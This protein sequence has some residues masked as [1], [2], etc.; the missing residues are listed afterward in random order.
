MLMTEE[1]NKLRLRAQTIRHLIVDTTMKAGGAHIGGG[2]SMLD[3]LVTLYFKYMNIDP[4]IPDDPDRDRFVLSKGHAAIGYIPTLA[5]R[6][7]FDKSLLNTFNKFQSPFGMHPDSLKIPGCDASTGSLGH[8]LPMALGMAISAKMQNKKYHTYCI[9][10]DGE[11][12]E[13]SNWEAAMAAAHYKVDNLLLFVDRNRH[14]IDG[15]VKEVMNIEPL[16]DKWKAFGWHVMEID[17]HDFNE[18]SSS[19]EKAKEI[20]GVPVVVI[21]STIKGKGVDYMEDQT[22]WHYGAIDSVMGQR[23]HESIDRMYQ[24]LN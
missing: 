22:K 20:K 21:A 19:I 12:N 8:G 13:G 2:L 1:L 4:A 3:V 6:G 7:F 10:G 5:E 15:P 24:E 18:I 23:A 11:L 14:M 17:G 9:V 16:S